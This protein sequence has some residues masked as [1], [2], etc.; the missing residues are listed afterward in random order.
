MRAATR[1]D[2]MQTSSGGAAAGRAP[3]RASRVALAALVALFA[4]GCVVKETRPLP[5]LTAIQ[6]TAEI[7]QEQLL[8]VGIRLFDP[9]L[10]AEA[11]Q[12][13]EIAEQLAA[14]KGIYAD[15]R[16]AES[17]Y[18][19]TVLRSTLEGTGHWG[20]VRVIPAG[21]EVMDV[22]VD[23]RIV[24]ATGYELELEVTVRGATGRLWFT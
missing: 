9:G 20:A 24:E 23:G 1:L 15:I 2:S 17:R 14:E 10:P 21:V 22:M 12:D 3:G 16:R 8:D 6:A 19:P 5:K 13:P 18:M 4:S 7:P 11:D